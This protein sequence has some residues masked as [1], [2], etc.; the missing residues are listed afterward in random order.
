MSKLLFAKLFYTLGVSN[1]LRKNKRDGI[2]IL[3]LHR[4]SPEEDYFWNP[5]KPASFESLLKYLIKHYNIIQFKE[6][7]YTRNGSSK[8]PLAILSF[9]DGYKDFYEYALPLLVKYKLPSNHNIVN[10][11]AHHNKAIWTQRLNAVFNSAMN[12]KQS[13]EFVFEKTKFSIKDFK[14]WMAFYLSIFKKMLNMADAEREELISQ[15]EHLIKINCKVEMMN[16]AEIAECA[17]HKVEIGSHTF[18]HD[19]IST[20]KQPEILEKE[21]TSSIKE[22][23]ERLNQSTDIIAWPNGQTSNSAEAIALQAG[24]KYS[25][26]VG[27]KINFSGEQPENIFYRINLV[28]EPLSSIILRTE[29]FYS[30]LKNYVGV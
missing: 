4:V 27:E 22:I 17:S 15:K 2:T 3:N 7:E 14:S 16:W 24:I 26:H 12:D 1:F 5:M 6:I 29:L 23:N 10:E 11:C 18:S 20:I 8:K 28:E 19:V 9:D 21:I 25:L 30:K 13:L